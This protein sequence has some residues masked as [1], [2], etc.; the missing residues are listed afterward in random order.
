MSSGF[1]LPLLDPRATW[2]VRVLDG[3]SGS[4]L[5]EHQAETQCETA[6]IGKVFLLIEVARR[7]EAGSLSLDQ[8]VS[9]PKDHMVADSGLL[10]LMRNQDLCLADMALLVSAFSDNLATNALIELCGL[11]SVRGVAPDLGY[12][13]TSL[14][15]YIR[16]ERT[17]D[18]P[19]TPSY[20][21]A[22]ELADLMLRLAAGQV[23]SPAVSKRVLNWLGSNADTT[24]VADALFADPLAH[25]ESDYQGV[26]LRNKTGTTEFARIDIGHVLGPTGSV[27][28]VVAANWKNVEV[29]LRVAVID[30]MREIGE[31]IRFAV[32]G[33]NRLD[34]A[35]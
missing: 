8:R 20:G 19:W 7:V 13:S 34:G 23:Y 9:A 17:P 25:L 35:A 11:E 6:S 10:Y 15:D 26:L 22:S 12:S 24:L 2:S 3:A 31:Q 21:T 28:Y 30:A 5:L 29:D 32:T 14:H 18:L 16:D 33:R 1:Q 4:P 27:A